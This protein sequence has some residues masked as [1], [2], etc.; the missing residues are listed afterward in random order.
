VL[1]KRILDFRVEAP[2]AI[3]RAAPYVPITRPDDELVIGYAKIDEGLAW[4][5]V[6]DV[7][8]EEAAFA[9]LSVSYVVDARSSEGDRR[10]EAVRVLAITLMSEARS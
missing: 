8:G 7:D 5:N 6:L 2:G 1:V 4:L 9:P 10:I 3:V